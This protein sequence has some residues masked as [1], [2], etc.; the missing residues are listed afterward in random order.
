MCF[1][2]D[3]FAFSLIPLRSLFLCF[4]PLEPCL[5]DWKLMNSKIL[6]QR[7]LASFILWFQ[8]RVNN[9]HLTQS[10][11]ILIA[12]ASCLSTLDIPN[13]DFSLDVIGE[14]FAVWNSKGSKSAPFYGNVLIFYLLSV[15]RLHKGF[16]CISK[17]YKTVNIPHISA[18]GIY[19]L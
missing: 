5:Q 1:N 12:I 11:L 10:C 15:F 7:Y 17:M 2:L 4:H 16:I 19:A 14:I 6:W 13:F 18:L 9:A 8:G 3:S